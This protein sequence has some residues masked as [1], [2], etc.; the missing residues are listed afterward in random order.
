M[1]VKVVK[2]QKEYMEHLENA[3][4]S[5]PEDY[6][7]MHHEALRYMEVGGMSL[8]LTHRQWLWK[9]NFLTHHTE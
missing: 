1:Q 6:K 7:Y 3:A 5:T 9:Y 2:E 4:K 8:I